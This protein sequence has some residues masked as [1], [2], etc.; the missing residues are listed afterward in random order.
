VLEGVNIQPLREFLE[1]Q[2][3]TRLSQR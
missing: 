2:I 3:F 1:G